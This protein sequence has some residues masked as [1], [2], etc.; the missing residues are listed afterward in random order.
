MEG[1]RKK[2]KTWEQR[3]V[4]FDQRLGWN[5]YKPLQF[6]NYSIPS[7]ASLLLW[8]SILPTCRMILHCWCRCDCTETRSF[9]WVI[10]AA[11][12]SSEN[13]DCGCRDLK[14]KTGLD[15]LVVVVVVS[16]SSL[17]SQTYS[18]LEQQK[19]RVGMDRW[20]IGNGCATSEVQKPNLKGNLNQYSKTHKIIISLM[21]CWIII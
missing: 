11:S 19:K 1:R 7:I 5:N 21:V 18:D 4:E 17:F 2:E 3:G 9:F 14:R 16:S 10:L 12:E 15:N 13:E 20:T 8:I 6:P